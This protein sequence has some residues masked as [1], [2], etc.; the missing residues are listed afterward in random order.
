MRA[1]LVAGS[2]AVAIGLVA[3]VAWWFDMSFERAVYLAPLIVLSFGALAALLVLWTRVALDPVLRR[4][5]ARGN[6]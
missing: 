1:P 6:P 2:A 3:L 4:R 5:R